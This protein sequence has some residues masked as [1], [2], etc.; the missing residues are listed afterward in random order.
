[1]K[2]R[3]WILIGATIAGLA[4]CTLAMIFVVG[5][6]TPSVKGDPMLFTS[7]GHPS[8]I[9]VDGS[10]IRVRYE[11]DQATLLVPNGNPEIEP[12]LAAARD[13]G[14]AVTFRVQLTG[15]HFDAD[16]GL[17]V[18]WVRYLSYRDK[19][20]G[21]YEIKVPWSWREMVDEQVALLK[22]IGFTSDG[23]YNAA[24]T[25]LNRSLDTSALRPSQRWLAMAARAYVYQHKAPNEPVEVGRDFLLVRATE[26]FAAAAKLR[27]DDYS[28]ATSRAA[29]LVDLGAYED[30]LVLLRRALKHSDEMHFHAGIMAAD[31]LRRLRRNAESLDILD[32]VGRRDQDQA[33]MMYYYH[34]GWT[35]LLLKRNPEAAAAFSEGLKSQ[36]NWAW[37]YI[38]RGCARHDMGDDDAALA[39]LQAAVAIADRA[40]EKDV[41]PTRSLRPELRNNIAALERSAANGANVTVCQRFEPNFDRPMR[42]RSKLLDSIRAAS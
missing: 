21:P 2:P 29:A 42:E 15:A 34:R 8:R 13:A 11:W 18:Y 31:L 10:S 32:E 19:N 17:P 28:L 6:S 9:E 30:A 36:K 22:G 7:A 35:L 40:V 4:F 5:H 39:D 33:G 1:M 12:M 38:G 24:L 41:E 20:F 14:E 3:H 23:Q 16:T 37:V 25:E 27:P 26:D